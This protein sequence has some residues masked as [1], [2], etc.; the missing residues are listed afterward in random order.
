[1]TPLLEDTQESVYM[2]LFIMAVS[3]KQCKCLPIIA[4]W[5][6]EIYDCMEFYI[7]EDKWAFAHALMTVP[8]T[9]SGTTCV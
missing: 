4:E 8:E 2:Y 9:M 3:N 6:R 1:M 7:N 5:V